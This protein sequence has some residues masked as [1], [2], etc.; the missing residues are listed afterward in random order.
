MVGIE[1]QKKEA[2]VGTVDV[3]P[4]VAESE[5]VVKAFPGKFNKESG[6]SEF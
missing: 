2:S 4:E 3:F 6:F 1:K 5:G